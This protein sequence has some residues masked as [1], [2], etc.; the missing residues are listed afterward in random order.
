MP[1]ARDEPAEMRCFPGF[2]VEVERLR[3]V[4]LRERL[5]V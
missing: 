1:A 5:D 3:V 2:F 4:A